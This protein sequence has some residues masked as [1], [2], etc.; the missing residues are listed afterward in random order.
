[1]DMGAFSQ[2]LAGLSIHL[3]LVSMAIERLQL[4]HRVIRY[5]SLVAQPEASLR[6]CLDAMHLPIP[7]TLSQ[8]R[9]L[10]YSTSLGSRSSSARASSSGGIE[11]HPFA[12][13][14]AEHMPAGASHR[15]VVATAGCAPRGAAAFP[16]PG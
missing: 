12:V 11:W 2:I 6:G 10:I 3:Q 8:A 15:L 14:V 1:M 7:I 4:N 13:D 16:A 5:E 9:E